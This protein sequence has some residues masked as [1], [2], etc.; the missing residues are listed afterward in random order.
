MP[1]KLCIFN[2]ITVRTLSYSLLATKHVKIIHGTVNRLCTASFLFYIYSFQWFEFTIIVVLAVFLH[3]YLFDV[4]LFSSAYLI[5]NYFLFYSLLQIHR[6]CCTWK[7]L[8]K[9]FSFYLIQVGYSATGLILKQ[10]I[11]PF[12]SFLSS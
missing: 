8:D 9:P 3:I 11:F 10:F 12:M 4:I 6:L 5:F 1:L 7:Y 2:K